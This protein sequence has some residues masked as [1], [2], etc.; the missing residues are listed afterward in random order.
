MIKIS[1]ELN[2]V[3][4]VAI[5]DIVG[6]ACDRG[7]C[8][9]E[10]GL[11]LNVEKWV[12]VHH[13]YYRTVDFYRLLGDMFKDM[14]LFRSHPVPYLSIDHVGGLWDGSQFRL[15][16]DLCS[17]LMSYLDIQLIYLEAINESTA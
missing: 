16:M 1:A 17:K 14:G 4:F 12:D 7:V 11:C 6:M 2:R 9:P 10:C 8:Y 3:L 5:H 13:P 15:R